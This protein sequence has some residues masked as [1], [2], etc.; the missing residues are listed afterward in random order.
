VPTITDPKKLFL[1]ELGDILT[2]ERVIT[3]M[4][5]TMKNKAND[6]KLADRLQQHLAETKRHVENIEQVFAVLGEQP[7]PIR[8]PAIEGLKAEHEEAEGEA[9][10]PELADLVGVG[11][12]ARI[13]HYEIA[14]YEGLIA[15][16]KGMGETKAARLLEGNLDDERSML[17]DGKAVARR[18]T[19]RMTKTR[20]R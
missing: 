13:E 1:H 4:L 12:G 19:N 17:R 11:V 3:Q 16:A 15:M 9:S 14:S 18:L 10:T 2:A 6:E 7:K 5:P 8:C 20:Q